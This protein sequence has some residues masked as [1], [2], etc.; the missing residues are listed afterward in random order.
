VTGPPNATLRAAPGPPLQGPPNGDYLAGLAGWTAFGLETP[1]LTPL[2]TGGFALS[3]RFDTT[4]VSPPFQVP[5]GA[6]ALSV[7]ARSLGL[8]ATLEVRARPEEGGADIPLGTLEP[9][10]VLTPMP[11]SLA[12]LAGR[13]IRVVLDPVPAIGRSVDVSAV[14]PV[15]TPLSSWAVLAGV[16]SVVAA[17]PRRELRVTDDPLSIASTPF[18]P[19][20]A[21]VALLIAVR[22]EGTVRADAGSGPV[23]VRA[24][25]PPLDMRV[26]VAPGAVPVT[27]TVEAQPGPAGLHLADV[28][29]VVRRTVMLDLRARRAGRRALVSGRLAPAGGGLRVELR[30]LAGRRLGAARTDAF[31]AFRLATAARVRRALV[32]TAGDRTRLAGGWRVRLPPPPRR[33]PPRPR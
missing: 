16:P 14:G 29:L 11:V 21:A 31:G 20:P 27:L 28:G 1:P 6:Q 30:T 4:V 5:P 10:T 3:L 32:R 33:R 7:T 26:P 9:P 12:G 17:S 18:A 2:P 8:G 24:S 15:E 23:Q 19:G 22:G 25:G 13:V